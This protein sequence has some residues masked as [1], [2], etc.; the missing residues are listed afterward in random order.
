ML[1]YPLG[2]LGQAVAYNY[3]STYLVV[4]LTNAVGMS[5]SDATTISAF[6]LFMEVV[7]GMALGNISDHANFKMG[8]RRP[9]L[10]IALCTVPFILAGLFY[11]VEFSARATFMYY[12]LFAVLFRIFF[13][14]FEIPN[15]AMGAEIAEGYDERTRL[16]T[17][18]RYFSI[19]GSLIAY[20]A[21]LWILDRF[22]E[23]LKAG[24]LATGLVV[25][26]TTALSWGV[27]LVKTRG[28]EK[29]GTGRGGERLRISAVAAS[30]VKN[31]AELARLKTMR[32]LIVYKGA[33][34]CSFA[35]YNI[36]IWYYLQ[37]SIGLSNAW[38]MAVYLLCGAMFF[39]STPIT[40]RLALRFG[41]SEQQKQVLFLG[42]VVC[43][44]VFLFCPSTLFG[45]AVYVAAFSV[46]QSGFWQLSSSIFYDITEI[47]EYVYGKRREGDIMSM[48]SVLG[49]LVTAVVVRLFGL[50]FDL[51]GFDPDLAVQGS[52]VA[53]FLNVSI[54]LAPGVFF[55]IGYLA[56]RHFPINKVTF[57]YLQEALALKRAG[58]SAAE[59]E[60]KLADVI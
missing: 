1:G 44:A 41:K 56:L 49:T 45:G 2:N 16:R 53:Q 26:L 42:G 59:F 8:R 46:V 22:P 12:M 57:G 32:L 20:M 28:K 3:V 34:A 51:A 14:C 29:P 7:A 21:P 30:I 18:C 40:N 6:A 58:K 54:L 35:L 4:F 27:E 52:A 47:D 19:V 31:Y 25:A 17:A 38:S 39:I 13:S 50:F 5:P 10:F 9:F 60:E 11:T 23:S 33:F 37:Y 24:W 48:V 15:N 36:G 43:V 55:F